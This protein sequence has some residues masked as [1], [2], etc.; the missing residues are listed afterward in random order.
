M[1]TRLNNP[2]HG[3]FFGLLTKW[4]RLEI[5]RDIKS[6]DLVED[7]GLQLFY[8]HSPEEGVDGGILQSTL[9]WTGAKD[10]PKPQ[11]S[12]SGHGYLCE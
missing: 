9:R 1:G 5:P 4:Y 8:S 6:I 10:T 11:I 7:I 3:R 12:K 2:V